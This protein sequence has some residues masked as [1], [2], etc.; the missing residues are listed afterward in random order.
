M[1]NEYG[2]FPKVPEYKSV[3]AAGLLFFYSF[4]FESAFFV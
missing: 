3:T 4:V 1:S 2:A